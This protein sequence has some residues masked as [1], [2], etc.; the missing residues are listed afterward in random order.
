MKRKQILNQTGVIL[1]TCLLI[2]ISP[3]VANAAN[4][5]ILDGATGTYTT[6]KCDSWATN[7]ACDSLPASLVRGDTYYIADGKYPGYIFNDAVDGTKVI[8]VKKAT[9]SDHG[10]DN[11]WLSTY[12]D[13]QAVFQCPM[14]K[15]PTD[16]T[17]IAIL[18]SYIT[19][20]GSVGSG[21]SIGSYGFRVKYPADMGEAD[22]VSTLRSDIHGIGLP[23]TGYT[24]LAVSN[25]QVRHVA[26]EGPGPIPCT[27]GKP[28]TC[29]NAGI[30]ANSSNAS[31]IKI[32]NNY[33]FGWQT[34]IS[35]YRVHDLQIHDNYLDSNTSSA[36]GGHGQQMNV[37]GTNNVL[38]YNN[39]FRNSKTFIMGAHAHIASNIGLSMYNNISYG[40]QDDSL[41]ACFANAGSAISNVIV[42]GN[43]HNN[44]FINV[45]CGG[46]GAVFVGSLTNVATQRSYAYN[47]L[48]YKCIN[49]RM[50]NADKNAGAIVHDN[51]AYLSC[52][53]IF[54][55]SDESAPLI[56]Y[57][58]PFVGAANGNYQ[59]KAGARPIN[60]GKT[61][62]SKYSIA[63]NGVARPQGGAWD[64]GAYE[65]VP[66][67][68]TLFVSSMNGTV[69][70]YPPGIDC[71]LTCYMNF[72]S[73]TSLVL[74]AVPDSGYTF[75]GWSG[76]GCSGTGSCTVYMASAQTV[77]ANYAA[78]LP[79]PTIPTPTY[80]L[81][82]SKMVNEAGSI[83]A[84]DRT[85]NCGLTCKAYYNPGKTVTLTV[86]TNS[87]YRFTRWT[88]ACQ[89]QGTTCTVK[90]D[91]SKNTKAYFELLDGTLL[92]SEGAIK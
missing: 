36:T 87:G 54:S 49:P 84:S 28:Y 59:L 69:T 85:I 73:E 35:L 75:T 44:T 7:R 19:F 4:Q 24:T 1:T 21:S 67:Q 78:V 5:Y 37:D 26:V 23:P 9:A 18:T 17:G 83:I 92:Y 64:I 88:G 43:F 29:S 57:A 25:I 22:N 53:G 81:A 15:V 14:M 62:I 58:D 6:T 33:L 46:R 65:Y 90:M 60:A 20:D 56:D 48:F 52:T 47:N 27:E 50:D 38:I 63:Y 61:L 77:T 79:A 71:G 76:G 41:T 74:K 8:T 39:V 45:N 2:L 66:Q 10:T 89:G 32:A 42:G 12:G 30:F 70:S 3:Q 86:S 55:G 13:G 16:K 91:T 34:Q 72:D 68:S 31:N 51:N 11:G 40:Q 82:V 80:Y